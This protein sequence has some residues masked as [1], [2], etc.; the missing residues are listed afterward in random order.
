MEGD[1]FS[2]TFV[3]TQQIATGKNQRAAQYSQPWKTQTTFP[4]DRL[5]MLVINC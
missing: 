4:S 3:T 5:S 1:L 2:E